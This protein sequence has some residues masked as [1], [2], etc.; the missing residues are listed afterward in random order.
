MCSFSPYVNVPCIV[1]TI[2]TYCATYP[3]EML[4]D[5]SLRRCD[6]NVH[7]LE[8]KVL[9]TVAMHPEPLQQGGAKSPSSVVLIGLFLSYQMALY[10]LQRVYRIGYIV[11]VERSLS[12]YI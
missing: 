9:S 3:N 11:T 5:P 10:P 1:R 2:D 12:S 8:P 4:R 6:R 7:E